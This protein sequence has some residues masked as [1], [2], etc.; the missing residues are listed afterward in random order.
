MGPAQRCASAQLQRAQQGSLGRACGHGRHS[1]ICLPVTESTH[2]SPGEPPP[3]PRA[4]THKCV[5]FWN[6][7][8][9][10]RRGKCDEGSWRWHGLAWVLELSS[11]REP[12]A[13][14]T[15]TPCPAG[16][17]AS[18]GGAVR[19]SPHMASAP[20]ARL[21]G[22]CSWAAPDLIQVVAG[23]RRSKRGHL[24]QSCRCHRPHPCPGGVSLAGAPGC[25]C[26]PSW[27]VRPPD[28]LT[29]VW[30]LAPCGPDPA[31]RNHSS[32]SRAS[33]ARP[34]PRSPGAHPLL[35]PGCLLAGQLWPCPA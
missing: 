29:W 14:P 27:V 16:P 31:L 23:K 25:C 3:T 18:L 6:P 9:G 32:C 35:E 19:D 5:P 4:P 22:R 30:L 2:R 13:G 17:G 11:D 21:L 7:G 8:I 20:V 24:G 12:S 28:A 34:S 26:G 33:P 10:S 1:G 15:A